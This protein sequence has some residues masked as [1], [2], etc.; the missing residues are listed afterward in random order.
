[1]KCILMM[2]TMKAGGNATTSWLQET[3]KAR[4][5]STKPP[6]ART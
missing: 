5:A 4:I 6:A 2:N 1:M 3:I